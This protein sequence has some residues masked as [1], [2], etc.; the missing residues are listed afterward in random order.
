MEIK[1]NPNK[2]GVDCS[3]IGNNHYEEEYL[4]DKGSEFRLVAA[5]EVQFQSGHGEYA[6][7]RS[8]FVYQFEEL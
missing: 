3:V 6:H 7:T 2:K 1:P 4:M 5:K 8:V